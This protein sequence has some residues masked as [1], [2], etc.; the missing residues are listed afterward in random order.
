VR[1]IEVLPCVLVCVCVFV[2]GVCVP[3]FEVF[4]RV[5]FISFFVC[6]VR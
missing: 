5:Q 6:C 2:L 1:T 3:N 4:L